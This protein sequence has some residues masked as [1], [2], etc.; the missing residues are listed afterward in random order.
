VRL[1]TVAVLFDEIVQ[2]HDDFPAFKA[3]RVANDFLVNQADAWAATECLYTTRAE[4][5]TGMKTVS[6]DPLKSGIMTGAPLV[7]NGAP[8]LFFPKGRVVGSQ[9]SQVKL[10]RWVPQ[11]ENPHRQLNS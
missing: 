1:P 7:T 6:T 3:S 2:L 5:E 10:K 4:A 9:A 8:S 11:N